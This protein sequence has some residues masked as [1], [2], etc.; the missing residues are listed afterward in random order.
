MIVKII[1]RLAFIV[2]LQKL[3]DPRHEQARWFF[4]LSDS[5]YG[6]EPNQLHSPSFRPH[7][8]PA[9]QKNGVCGDFFFFPAAE[10]KFLKK[11]MY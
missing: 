4:R 1:L 8:I 6:F 11:N 10:V 7:K 2:K 3:A 5:K 9:K